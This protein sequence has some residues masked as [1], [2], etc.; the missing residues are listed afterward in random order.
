MRF[1]VCRHCGKKIQANKK[2]KH[3][4]QQYCGSPPCQKAR[5]LS[6]ERHKYNKDPA[7]RLNKL[8]KAMERR[9]SADNP[10][11]AS[12]YQRQ[13]R[14]DHPGY[15]TDNRIKQLERNRKKHAQL[16]PPSKIVNPDA[17]IK[18]TPERERVYAMVEVHLPKIVNPDTFMNQ[19]IDR[20]IVT[21]VQPMLVKIL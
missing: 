6:F 3:L 16:T 8:R 5:K 19:S 10:S 4:Q 20:M 1:L 7:Y 15:V 14:L 13:Y 9:H 12:Q 2:L 18:Q 17:F 21:E 11:L